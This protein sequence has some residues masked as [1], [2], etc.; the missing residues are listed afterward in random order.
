MSVLYWQGGR[1]GG[2]TTTRRTVDV[3][4]FKHLFL[5][6]CSVY[7]SKHLLFPLQICRRN[8][9]GSR[10]S[11]V[12]VP[13]ASI[14]DNAK[15]SVNPVPK[16]RNLKLLHKVFADDVDSSKQFYVTDVKYYDSFEAVCCFCVPYH[17]DVTAAEQSAVN[18]H[19]SSNVDDYLYHCSFFR[20]YVA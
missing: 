15:S 1:V 19:K 8:D 14:N 17:G 4:Y 7:Y 13:A 18:L 5:I 9:H 12:V 2:A 16:P 3:Y 20:N 10:S 6:Q 11:R